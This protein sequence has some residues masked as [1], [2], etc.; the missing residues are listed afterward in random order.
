M[1]RWTIP[2]L[3]ALAAAALAGEMCRADCENC[4]YTEGDLWIGSGLEDPFSAFALYWAGDLHRVVSVEFDLSVE[5]GGLVGYDFAP[6]RHSTAIWDVIEEH[7]AEYEEFFHSWSP[8]AVIEGDLPPGARI[9]SDRPVTGPFPRMLLVEGVWEKGK[10]FP[11]PACGERTL[12]FT[13][14]GE[15]D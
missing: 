12:R 15:W 14:T 1:N 8:P 3:T 10:V 7:S 2:I 11:C 4:G 13:V 5:F 9:A 6:V